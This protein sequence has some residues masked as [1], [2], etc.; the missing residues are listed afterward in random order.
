MCVRRR[1]SKMDY[2]QIV[3]RD[4]KV[5][6]WEGVQALREGIRR[7]KVPS[8][9]WILSFTVSPFWMLSRML[10]SWDRSFSCVCVYWW[11]GIRKWSREEEA[12]SRVR[13]V[14][15]ALT[16]HMCSPVLSPASATILLVLCLVAQSCPTLCNPM[17]C[18]PPGSMGILQARIL[19]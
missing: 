13:G 8:S 4:I 16:S 14:N 9:L 19:E 18:S 11:L 6:H 1:N 2:V 7:I 15:N 17:D 5:G 10:P 12:L 3:I